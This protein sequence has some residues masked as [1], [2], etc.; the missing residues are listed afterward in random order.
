[1]LYVFLLIGITMVLPIFF[2]LLYDKYFDK[3]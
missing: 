2:R 3:D 1:M